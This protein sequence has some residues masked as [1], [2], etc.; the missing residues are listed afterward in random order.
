MTAEA[1]QCLGGVGYTKEYPVEQYM[2]DSKV[3][4]IWEG[5]SFIHGND[6]VGRKMTMDNG[7][8]FK[9][10]MDSIKEFIDT[11]KDVAGLEK[12]IA[13]L[14]KAYESAEEVW[15]QIA[16]WQANKA[17]KGELVNLYAIRTLF[18]FAQLYVAVCLLDQAIIA[19]KT[20]AELPGDHF[21]LNF[22]KGKVASAVYYVNNSL[23]NVFTLAQVIKNAD[24]SVL[25]V[26][27]EVL[28]V[29]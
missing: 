16:A 23:P 14:G 27:E 4:T 8:P 24:T 17:E 10:W 1:I 28:I 29:N 11:N 22:Y 5:T 9:K 12:E 13:V 19:K 7:E 15:K 2:R 20:M 18:V 25:E 26:P 3:L 21:E 6:L